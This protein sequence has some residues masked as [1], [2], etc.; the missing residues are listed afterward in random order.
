MTAPAPTSPSPTAPR[1]AAEPLGH[2]EPLDGIRAVAVVGVLLYHS[3]Y[4]WMAGGFLGV[5]VF[6]TLSG[7]L[8]TSLLL[9]EWAAHDRID[10]RAFWARRFRRLLPASLATLALVVAMGAVG[11]WD[12]EQLRS[13]RGDV[14]W[15]VAELVNWHFIASGT[16]YGNEYAGSSPVEHYWSLAIE[17][18]FYL[19]LPLLLTALLVLGRRLPPRIRLGRAAV[20]LGVLA[21][22]SSVVNGWLSQT[23]V[24]RAYFGTDSRAAELL[25]GALLACATLRRLR[26]PAGAARTAV[27]AAAVVGL[28]ALGVLFVVGDL[29]SRWLYP[30][31]LLVTAACTAAVVLGSAQGGPAAAL[32]GTRPLVALGRI[33]YGVYLIHWPVY[34]WLTPT[35]T[36]L[37]GVALLGL[38]GAVTLA[39]AALSYRLLEQPIRTGRLLGTRA[40]ALALPLAVVAIVSGNLAATS[41]L[42]PPPDFLQAR[43]P[44]DDVVVREASTTTTTTATTTTTGAAPPS[45]APPSTAAPSPTTAAPPPTAPPPTAPPTTVPP[46]RHPTRVLL[47]GD[48]VAASLE[49]YLGDALTA[50]GITFAAATSPGCGVVTGDPADPQ[51]RPIEFTR[52]CHGAIPRIQSDAVRKARPDLVVLLSSWEAGDRIVDGRWYRFGTA[53]ADRVLDRLYGETFGRVAGG[54]TRVALVLLPPNVDGES[55]TADP[56]TNV[57]LARLAS[58]LTG[59]AGRSPVRPKLLDLRPIVCPTSPCPT[60]VDGIRLRP[61][62]GAHYDAAPGGRYVAERLADRIAALDLAR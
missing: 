55:R 47:L 43:A 62:D 54:G 1:I 46:P 48:S 37:D 15:S 30:W 50:R 53:E 7:F 12:T 49:P 10:L 2:I 45:T 59:L 4:D 40:A 32:L 56:E 20:A 23:S 28:A 52:A 24:D 60:V 42:E 6:F 17:E 38:R 41:G 11:V 26:L 25:V 5:S 13:L 39:A 34:L 29:T 21:V 58:Y 36:G 61:G 33:S 8:I 18:Q 31:G 16:S 14:P 27:R 3:A 51:G 35:R 22:A 44:D 19:A 57:R 9:R